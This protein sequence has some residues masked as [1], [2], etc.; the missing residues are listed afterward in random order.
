MVMLVLSFVFGVKYLID[1]RP[2]YYKNKAES[3]RV[4]MQQY[5]NIPEIQAWM[6]QRTKP[7]KTVDVSPEEWPECL[8]KIPHPNFSVSFDGKVLDLEEGSG[9]GHWGMRVGIP[10]TRPGKNFREEYQLP[11]TDDAYVYH[12]VQ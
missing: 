2:G 9:F 3:F 11:F 12:E 1:N 8:K 7:V 5:A 4:R 6:A 10:G